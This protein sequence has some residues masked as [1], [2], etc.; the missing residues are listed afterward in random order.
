MVVIYI[1]VNIEKRNRIKR[2]LMIGAGILSFGFLSKLT[3]ADIILG[4]NTN[5]NVNVE[6]I[7]T[8]KDYR[9]IGNITI[10]RTGEII[11]SITTPN[12]TITINRTGNIIT[13]Y[14]D[15]KY[16]WTINRDENDNITSIGVSEK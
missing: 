14:E 13:S 10:N 4:K 2:N 12:R 16:E 9:N 15:S 7:L 6:N 8:T 1:S 5:T 3:S 11:T